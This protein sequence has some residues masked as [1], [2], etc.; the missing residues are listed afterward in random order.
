MYSQVI[1]ISNKY[2]KLGADS[3]DKLEIKDWNEDSNL[4]KTE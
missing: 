4:F 2:N 3:S 1:I